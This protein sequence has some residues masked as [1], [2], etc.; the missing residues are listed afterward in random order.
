MAAKPP[1]EL[2]RYKKQSS[3]K[4]KGMSQISILE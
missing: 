3:E 1:T 4:Q 2:Y